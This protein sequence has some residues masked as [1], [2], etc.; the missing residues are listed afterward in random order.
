MSVQLRFRL[1]KSV[2]KCPIADYV[3]GGELFTHLYQR[4]YFAER[5]VQ[6]YIAEV[7]IALEKLHSVS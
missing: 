6:I 1:I 4:D 3:S 7:V 2:V 5:D